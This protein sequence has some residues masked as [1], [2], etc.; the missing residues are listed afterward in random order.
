MKADVIIDWLSVAQQG[1]PANGVARVRRIVDFFD[2]LNQTDG[3]AGP[4]QQWCGLEIQEALTEGRF[5]SLHRAYD[6][7]LK[8]EVALKLLDDDQPGV[9]LWLENS[10]RLARVRHPNVVGILGTGSDGG[11]IGI[12]MELSTG[13]P[14]ESMLKSSAKRP[15]AEWVELIKTLAGA[16]DAVHQRSLLHGDVQAGNILVEPSGRS[17]LIDFGSGVLRGEHARPNSPRST[18]PEILV[19]EPVEASAD[20]W[21]LGT[22]FYRGLTGEEAYPVKTLA[23]LIKA[24]QDLPDL[25]KVPRSL[26][27]TLKAMLSFDPAKRPSASDVVA[28]LSKTQAEPP[29][30]RLTWALAGVILTLVAGIV[31]TVMG[32]QGAIE[33]DLRE[34]QARV[35]AETTLSII[36]DVF[37]AEFQGAQGSEA[38]LI[39]ALERAEQV[40]LTR[41]DLPADV[42]A[43]LDILTGSSYLDAGRQDRGM[44]LLDRSLA[45]LEAGDITDPEAIAL[46]LS[47][48]AL[49]ICDEASSRTESLRQN[50][51]QRARNLPDDHRLRTASLTLQACVAERAGDLALAQSHLRQALALRPPSAYPGDIAAMGAQSRLG[52]LLYEQGRLADAAM[53]VEQAYNGLYLHAGPDHRE[54]LDLA[55]ILG[56]IQIEREQYQEAV[57]LLTET[58]IQIERRRGDNTLQW[59]DLSSSLASAQAGAGAFESAFATT[60]SLIE[61]ANDHLGEYHPI[62]LAALGD[63]ALRLSD[64]GRSEDAAAA[65]STALEAAEESLEPDHPLLQSL[66]KQANSLAA[67]Q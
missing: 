12:W 63:R 7:K 16:L 44:E 2:H 62:T 23:Q 20:I 6:P 67:S 58:L 53:L 32:W 61:R 45:T 13:V 34:E 29:Q 4:G 3:H 17:L 42:R 15:Q 54:T 66:R 1:A 60:E 8:R 33:T 27:G 30:R 50:I 59:I 57:L 25:G 55:P 51:R 22:L 24:Q 37:G 64:L 47:E 43:T 65:M 5:A 9:N 36:R 26:R 38:R 41:T 39:D 19:G 48:Q 14:L 18:A 52:R 56:A 40:A 21:S 31:Y 49:I 28:M 10:R 35:R 46:I 11:Q